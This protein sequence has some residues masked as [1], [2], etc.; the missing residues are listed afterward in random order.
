MNVEEASYLRNVHCEAHN[1]LYLFLEFRACHTRKV[2][3]MLCKK[4]TL[5]S[6]YLIIIYI[7]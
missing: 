2:P 7:L 5:F 3:I 6:N 4:L 1:M